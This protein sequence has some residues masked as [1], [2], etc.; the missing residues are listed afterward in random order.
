[1]AWIKNVKWIGS[2]IVLIG[3]LTACSVSYKFNGASIDY[4]KTKTI[5]F[6]N[7]PNRSVGFVWGP[8]ENMFNTALQDGLFAA[9]ASDTGKT[10]RR[11][12]TFGRNHKL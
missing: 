2:L 9:N 5:S 12:A 8:M 11:F 3:I 4:A 6:E 1:M 10:R 7:F